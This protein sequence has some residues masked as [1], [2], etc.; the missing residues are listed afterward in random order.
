[1][2]SWLNENIGLLTAFVGIITIFAIVLS[3]IIALKIQKKLD[4]LSDMRERKLNVFKTLM[5]TRGDRNSRE[6]I[7]ALNMIDV[8]F[9]DDTTVIDSWNIY[10]CELDSSLDN[11]KLFI[12]LLFCMATALGYDFSKTLLDECAYSQMAH[13]QP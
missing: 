8:E 4:I 13:N 5:A 12:D 1:M 7:E 6:H 9:Y 10:R 11:T 3:P 2:L